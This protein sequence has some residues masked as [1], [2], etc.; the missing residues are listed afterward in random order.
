MRIFVTGGNGFVGSHFIRKALAGGHQVTAICR[1][2][3]Y[4][5][6]VDPCGNLQWIK[7]DLS[8]LEIADFEGFDVLAHFAAHGVTPKP[9]T[10][11]S[12]FQV[13]V[14][15]SLRLI[16]LAR[17][18]DVPKIVVS[19]SYAEYGRAGLRYD[20]IPVDAPLEPTDPYA[21]SKA[22]ASIAFASYA[23][24][25]SL[26]LF[27]GRIFSAFGE[28]QH[29][30]NFWPA[31]RKAALSGEDFNMTAG[32]QVRDFV[33]VTEV[34]EQFLRACCDLELPAGEPLFR[35][36]AS[37]NPQ[38]LSAFAKQWWSIFNATGKLNIGNIP[39]RPNEVMRYQALV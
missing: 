35:N 31:L 37:G 38:T 19:G 24:A 13:N 25:N 36:I 29:E 4:C 11:Q 27:Y 5:S 2:D 15:E 8:T 22:A 23:R 20:Y 26:S 6:A 1:N 34:A 32:E 16:D 33:A 30:S 39:Y 3:Q 14:I 21:A 28:G 10:W 12:A 7:A 9:C 18:A 17:L